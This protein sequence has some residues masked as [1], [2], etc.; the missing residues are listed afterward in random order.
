MYIILIYTCTSEKTGPVYVR[1]ITLLKTT[2]LKRINY[3][4]II[5]LFI[6]FLR[7]CTNN[8]YMEIN[9]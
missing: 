2:V 6:I 5:I 8:I 7:Y 3:I 1:Y 9:K 4:I